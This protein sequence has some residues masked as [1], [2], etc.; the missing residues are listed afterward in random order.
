[1]ISVDMLLSRIDVQARS[2]PCSIADGKARP[3][4]N[5]SFSRSNTRML[6]STAMPTDKTN[7]A[8]PAS[9]I[10][11]GPISGPSLKIII[12]TEM[13]VNSADEA[14]IPGRR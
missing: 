3:A 8:I 13:Y 10:V 4:R 14:R 1:M 9:V 11:T 6:A 5:S 12:T 7:P 2:K